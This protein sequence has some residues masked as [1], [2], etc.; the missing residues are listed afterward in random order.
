[1][2]ELMC[3]GAKVSSRLS[4][5]RWRK[6]RVGSEQ[7]GGKGRIAADCCAVSPRASMQEGYCR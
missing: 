6:A 5:G 7:A 4:R 1:M 2:W 3:A